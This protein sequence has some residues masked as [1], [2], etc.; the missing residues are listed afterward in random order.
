MTKE[1][2]DRKVYEAQKR[3]EWFINGY[4]IHCIPSIMWNSLTTERIVELYNVDMNFFRP[5]LKEEKI[6]KDEYEQEFGFK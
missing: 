3:I 1:E 2:I 4:F 5:W 6:E